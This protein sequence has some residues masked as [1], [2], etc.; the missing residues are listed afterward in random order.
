MGILGKLAFWKKKDDF[1]D[2]GKELGLDK[3]IGS[4][5]SP[6]LGLGLDTNSPEAYP[7]IQQPSQYSPPQMHPVQGFQQ[8][9][10]P[11]YAQPQSSYQDQ[12]Y[13][14]AKNLE[15]ISSKLDALRAT[16]EAISQRLANLENMA[17]GEQEQSKRR[18]Y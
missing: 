18:Y 10:Y 13:I 7:S 14:T 8:Q 4:G 9:G 12:N 3:D 6:D 16:M 15:V 5:M 11:Q 1:G 2:I 17:R